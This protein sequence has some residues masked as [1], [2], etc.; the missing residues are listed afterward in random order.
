MLPNSTTFLL[1]LQ[2]RVLLSQ[3]KALAVCFAWKA[4]VS[5]HCMAAS[6]S[7]SVRFQFKCLHLRGNFW[8]SSLST[9]NLI[10]FLQC[11]FIF[12]AFIIIFLV[13]CFMSH[14]KYSK[15]TRIFIHCFQ[16]YQFTKMHTKMH[17]IAPFSLRSTF[18]FNY[19]TKSIKI[20]LNMMQK[21]S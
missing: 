3:G 8:L 11:L 5:G 7:F 21:R 2:R 9:T 4:A 17:L 14:I 1:L 13:C 16:I 12:V 15:R 18:L 20:Y 10:N 19:K 6:F